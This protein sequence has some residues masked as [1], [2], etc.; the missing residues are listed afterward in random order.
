MKAKAV[1]VIRERVLR[2]GVGRR[3]EPQRGEPKFKP[4]IERTTDTMKTYILRDPQSVQPQKA[5]FLVTPDPQSPPSHA[6]HSLPVS[7]PARAPV[8]GMQGS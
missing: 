8:K 2:A 6:R 5:P 4:L 1:S 7:C 3:A